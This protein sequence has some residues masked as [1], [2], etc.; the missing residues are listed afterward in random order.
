M[1]DMKNSVTPWAE[2][3]MKN[4]QWLDEYLIKLPATEKEFQPIWQ[5][6]KYRLGGKMYAYIGIDDRNGRPIITLKLEPIF[7]DILRREYEDIVPGYYMN[8]VH[9]STVYLDGNVP[10]NVLA[11]IVYASYKLV[12]SLL[13]KK[14][15]QEVSKKQLPT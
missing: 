2:D 13:S 15:Q 11:D 9:W 5:A 6:Y 7:S 1:A 4:Y 3:S 8:K 10:Q 14:A 12:Y